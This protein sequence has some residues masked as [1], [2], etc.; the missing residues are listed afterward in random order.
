MIMKH[1]PSPHIDRSGSLEW[2]VY[3]LA[4]GVGALAATLLFV[5]YFGP[6]PAVS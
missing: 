2:A 4:L 5:L 6:A 3:A 1:T